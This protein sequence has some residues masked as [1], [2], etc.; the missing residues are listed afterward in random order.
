VIADSSGNFADLRVG[1]AQHFRSQFHP[2]CPQHCRN[3]FADHPA[4]QSAQLN[5]LRETSSANSVRL[6]GLAGSASNLVIN[7]CVNACSELPSA[8]HMRVSIYTVKCLFRSR[9]IEVWFSVWI[10][11]FLQTDAALQLSFAGLSKL[12]EG[13]ISAEK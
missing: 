5:G 7:R 11:H 10:C 3:R 9:V 8:V 1:L 12:F 2:L 6:G 13:A 4:E